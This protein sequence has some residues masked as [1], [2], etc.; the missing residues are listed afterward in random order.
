MG[1]YLDLLEL[2]TRTLA[3]NPGAPEITSIGID[4]YYMYGPRVQM[5]L[6]AAEPHVRASAVAHWAARLGGAVE[7]TDRD[8]YVHVA[9]TSIVEGRTVEIWTNLGTREADRLLAL[10][11]G[12]FNSSGRAYVDPARWSSDAIEQATRAVA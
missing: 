6:R 1:V 2:A 11:G 3:D 8:S 7:L 9:A 10:A 12:K 5:Q 4:D